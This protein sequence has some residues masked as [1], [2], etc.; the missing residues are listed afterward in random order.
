MDEEISNAK[1]TG[2]KLG[3]DDH[4]FFTFSIA[5]EGDGFG[6]NLGGYA[7]SCYDKAT[8]KRKGSEYGLN[9]IMRI[10]EVVG[11]E[12]WEDLK[13]KYVRV[14]HNGPGSTMHTLGNIIKDD[15]IDFRT[16]REGLEDGNEG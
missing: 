5:V 1:I 12:H 6:C 14:T 3:F 8:L 7:L 4:G 10:L 9:V 15:W 2:T 11:V 13:G 16:Y